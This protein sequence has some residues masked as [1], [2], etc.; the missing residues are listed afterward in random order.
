MNKSLKFLAIGLA[1]AVLLVSQVG[2][3]RTAEA[4]VDLDDEEVSFT[5]AMGDEKEYFKLDDTVN[6]YVK[7]ADLALPTT[8]QNSTVTFTLPDGESADGNDGFVLKVDLGLSPDTTRPR[9]DVCSQRRLRP[10]DATTT[11]EMIAYGAGKDGAWCQ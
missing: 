8:N 11:A 1:L 4:Q 9:R 2:V 6:F 10:V 3:D 5:N 7:A